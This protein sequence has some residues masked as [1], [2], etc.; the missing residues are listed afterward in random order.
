MKGRHDGVFHWHV[1]QTLGGLSQIDESLHPSLFIFH[2]DT[3]QLEPIL[4]DVKID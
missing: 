2:P 3:P 4:L 1:R